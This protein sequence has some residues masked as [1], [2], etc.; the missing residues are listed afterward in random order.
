MVT[1]KNLTDWFVV[2]EVFVDARS[3]NTDPIPI[4]E[5]FVP[6]M[7]FELSIK[8]LTATPTVEIPVIRVV[9]IPIDPEELVVTIP[10]ALTTYL[11]RLLPL[12]FMC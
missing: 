7:K 1:P 4:E 11:K 2:T 8:L 3:A 9:V 5:T 12:F 10:A 6:A